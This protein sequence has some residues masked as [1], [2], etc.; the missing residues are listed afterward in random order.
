MFQ[1]KVI[2]KK[3]LTKFQALN[4]IYEK[5]QEKIDYELCLERMIKQIRQFKIIMK[6]AGF[7]NKE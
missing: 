7:L 5:G 4:Y 3:S 6:N 1:P 2:N